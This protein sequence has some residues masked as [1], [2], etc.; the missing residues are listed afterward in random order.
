MVG[1]ILFSLAA[2]QGVHV[3]QADPPGPCFD[4]S[5]SSSGILKWILQ[6]V[7]FTASTATSTRSVDK[8]R[9]IPGG[10]CVTLSVECEVTSADGSRVRVVIAQG[11]RV[12]M[13]YRG[14]LAIEGNLGSCSEDHLIDSY[15]TP[16]TSS[17]A[18]FGYLRAVF[19][20]GIS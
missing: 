7:V 3:A 16:A 14:L 5:S 20:K 8:E 13:S 2:C 9:E 6:G 1:L 15:L 17:E 12:E 4:E 11:L 10:E 18:P 19:G